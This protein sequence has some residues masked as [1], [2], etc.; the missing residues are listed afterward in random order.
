MA[1]VAT[2]AQPMSILN[3]DDGIAR[4]FLITSIQTTVSYA[5]TEITSLNLI[6]C[7][8]R[9][10]PDCQLMCVAPA[11]AE[12]NM[13]QLAINQ[14]TADLNSCITFK[15]VSSTAP[16]FKLKFTPLTGAA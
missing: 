11:S 9:V 14:L 15:L 4:V 1:R 7:M 12:A 13:I 6:N 2:Y 10:I 16:V 5:K 8:N 3:L